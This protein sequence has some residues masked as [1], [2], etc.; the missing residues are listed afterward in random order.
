VSRGSYLFIAI[1][2]SNHHY[3]MRFATEV[4]PRYLRPEPPGVG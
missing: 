4:S 3:L 1:V 2:W